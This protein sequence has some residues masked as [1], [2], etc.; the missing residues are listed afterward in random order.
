M[1]KI[2]VGNWK[3]NKSPQEVEAWFHTFATTPAPTETTVILAVPFVYLP[4][5][6]TLI[7]QHSLTWLQLAAQDCSPYPLGSYTG[8]VA[9]VMLKDMAKYCLVGHSER[10]QHFHE[11]HQEIANKIEELQAASITPVLCVDEEYAVEQLNHLK[12][13]SG[14]IVAYEPL[15]AIGTG[16]AADPTKVAEVIAML[17]TKLPVNTPILYG[18][19]TNASNAE[20]FLTTAEADGLLPGSSSL[21]PE[22]FREMITVCD[23]H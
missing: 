12:A 23:R 2:L 4:L 18:G 5:A 7:Q 17:K 20:E 3:S 15:A 14:L 11:S 19:S 22:V 10:R 16:V 8:A 21:D 6:K 13:T 9:A 1:K